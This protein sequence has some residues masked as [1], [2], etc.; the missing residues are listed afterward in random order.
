MF[1]PRPTVVAAENVLH[2][3]TAHVHPLLTKIGLGRWV[4]LAEVLYLAQHS[5][6]AA[7][8]LR[9]AF[10]RWRV[11]LD[12]REAAKS[13]GIP[14]GGQI[15]RDLVRPAVQGRLR[16]VR[17]SV[18]AYMLRTFYPVARIRLQLGR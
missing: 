18:E 16:E 7:E 8:E 11:S 4:P 3:L 6:A 9:T 10:R 1:L 14:V 5:R 17:T 13:A 12:L 2:E 15:W